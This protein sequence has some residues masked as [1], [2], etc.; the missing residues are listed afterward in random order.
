MFKIYPLINFQV[1]LMSDEVDG[2][3]KNINIEIPVERETHSAILK[4]VSKVQNSSY[5]KYINALSYDT[6]EIRKK[7]SGE[8]EFVSSSAFVFLKI[9]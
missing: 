3:P 2:L 4:Q 5:A 8:L 1:S 9:L 7:E 6:F